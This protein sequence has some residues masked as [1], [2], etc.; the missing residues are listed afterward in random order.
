MRC[1]L[2]ALMLLTRCKTS[3]ETE[4]LVLRH[5]NAV[6]RR[7]AG[8]VRY[9][10]A[11]RLWLAALSRLIPRHRWRS[12]FPVTPATLPAWH[13]RLLSRVPVTRF[14]FL[15]PGQPQI[16]ISQACLG[17][18]GA[19]GDQREQVTLS[20][21]QRRECAHHR[22]GVQ[23]RSRAACRIC[24]TVELAIGWPGPDELVLHTPVTPPRI[25]RR[26][27]D[28]ELPDRGCRGRPVGTPPV[29]IV[30]FA[31]VQSPGPGEQRRRVTANTA[32]CRRSTSPLVNDH[33]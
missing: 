20:V 17:E 18:P 19:A 7:Q 4:L 12:V 10:P 27:A 30:P 1:L 5:E 13:R 28:H 31:C 33:G 32:P 11:D 9:Q 26:H 23:D 2:S 24:H 8:R 21:G 15:R 3:R 22:G 25:V 29:H 16:T 14:S 6:L